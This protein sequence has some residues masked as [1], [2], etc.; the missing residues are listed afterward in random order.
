[1]SRGLVAAAAR[2]NAEWCGV[3]CRSRGI[4]SAIEGAAWV[5]REDAPRFYPNLVTLEGP[6]RAADHH[7]IARE[8]LG[9]K[10]EAVAIKDSFD[11]LDGTVLACRVLFEAQWIAHDSSDRSVSAEGC[12]IVETEPELIAW[13]RAWSDDPGAGQTFHPAILQD[14]DVAVLAIRRDD[15]IV[16]GGIA[17]RA[18]GVVGISN[19]FARDDGLV[20]WALLVAGAARYLQHQGPFVGYEHGDALAAAVAGGWRP[21]GARRSRRGCD[22]HAAA[23]APRHRL[24]SAGGRQARPP[25][26]ASRGD[27]E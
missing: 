18:A 11:A 3:V 25:R 15:T 5:A 12:S 27:I 23:G 6:H 4:A 22:L 21:I 8:L 26:K 19:V 13:E 14:P 20:E 24:R 2:N 1:V 7:R 17:S 9:C 10:N 16:G